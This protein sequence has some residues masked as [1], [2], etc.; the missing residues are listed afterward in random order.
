MAELIAR[1]PLLPGDN[2]IHQLQLMNEI[3]GSPSEEELSFVSSDRAKRFM[4]QLPQRPRIPFGQRFPGINPLAADLLEKMLVMNPA[5]R[6]SVDAALAHPYLAAFSRGP[7]DGAN[8]NN[9]SCDQVFDF[10]FEKYRLDMTAL[11]EIMW[12]EMCHYHPSAMLDLNERHARGELRIAN[13]PLLR[14]AVGT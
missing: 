11:R 6:I 5:H 12:Q 1:K 3:L 10:Q 7:G 14:P 9:P 8:V 2:Y 13:L 4:L